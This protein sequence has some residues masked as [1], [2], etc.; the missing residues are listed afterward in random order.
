MRSIYDGLLRFGS[1]LE[2]QPAL[3]SQWTTSQD[4]TLYSFQVRRGVRFHDGSSCDAEAIVYNLQR[5]LGGERVR[6]RVFP[7]RLVRSARATDAQTVE[8]TLERPFAPF[9]NLLAQVGAS[10]VSPE[11]H[12]EHRDDLGRR[13]VGSGPF[14]L[15]E[16]RSNDRIVLERFDE[17]WRGRP[18]LDR[19]VFRPL[20]DASARTLL[21]VAGQ[22]HLADRLP[23]E[24]LSQVEQDSRFVID[25]LPTALALGVAINTQIRP[26]TDPKVRQALNYAIDK[27]LIVKNVFLRR[28]A[29]LNGPVPPVLPASG[30]ATPY[31][32]DQARARQLLTDAGVANLELPLLGPRNRFPRDVELLTEVSR[33]LAT[34]GVK[35]R[36]EVQDWSPY[37]AAL[38][39]PRIESTV[40]LALQGWTSPSADLY[41]A[42]QPLFSSAEQV[43]AGSNAAL[44]ESRAFDDALAQAVKAGNASDQARFFGQAQETVRDDAPWIFLVSPNALIAR[45]R[46]LGGLRW[47]PLDGAIVTEETALAADV[48][49]IAYLERSKR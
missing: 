25:S 22:A 1:S 49:P 37:V 40:R 20:G 15:V 48:P 45:H 33:Q 43:P 47:S 36:L 21:L 28:A 16:W 10:I 30:R 11:A 27:D 41:G 19:A 7:P 8:I 9:L 18:K 13:P 4:G 44:Y 12:R 31:G 35:T 14:R 6:R 32:L 17:G 3:A 34:V 26:L 39:K 29:V 2:L 38:V 23:L 5:F 24:L 42:L 46:G